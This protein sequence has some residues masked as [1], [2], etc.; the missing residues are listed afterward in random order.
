MKV[1]AIDSSGITASVAIVDEDVTIASYTVN[2]KKTHSQT[3]LPMIDEIVKMTETDLKDIDGIVISGGPGSFTGL[4]IGSTTAKGLGMALDKPLV[5]I[6]TLEGMAYQVYGFEG[7]ICP[8]MD[9]RRNQVYTGLYTFQNM[10]LYTVMNQCNIP[11]EELIDTLNSQE[12]PIMLLGDGVPVYKEQLEEGLTKPYYYAP[13]FLNRQ[14][15]AALGELGIKYLKKGKTETALEHKPNYLRI[16]QAERER[17]QM[18]ET[19]QVEIRRTLPEDI[20]T[21]A[22][23]EASIFADSWSI[24]SLSETLNQPH[25]IGLVAEKA[26]KVYGYIFVTLLEDAEIL[27]LAVAKD[28][29]HQGV[30]KRLMSEVEKICLEEGVKRLL[31]E[32]RASNKAA[33]D[34]YKGHGFKVDGV[35]KDYYNNPV[36]DGILMSKEGRSLC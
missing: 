34:F 36:E 14:N 11:L 28:K 30:G 4:R 6:P 20:V 32:V 1:L 17:A 10:D 15:A 5:N 19:S 23:M 25:N 22:E 33:I 9:A 2:Y 18:I 29:R 24:G 26:G 31:L 35:R 21:I 27:N 16:S 12:L 8:I 13:T 3:I 7:I